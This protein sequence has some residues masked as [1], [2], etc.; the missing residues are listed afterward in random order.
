MGEKIYITG[1]MGSQRM[2]LGQEIAKEKNLLLIDLDK[3]IEKK[4]GRTIK[5]ISMMMGEHAYHDKEY[6][7]LK[8]LQEKE[9]FVLV[10][11][12]G[13]LFDNMCEDIIAQGKVV[14]ADW[15]ESLETLWRQ[16]KDDKSL[17]YA[18]LDVLRFKAREN[19]EGQKME[20][21]SAYKKFCQI[22][23]E[24]KKYFLKYTK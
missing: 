12:D 1:P 18:F 6:H 10:C 13:I 24:R 3:E 7:L 20:E 11:G 19:P 23:E 21:A 4:D 17:P 22:H 5:K 16:A 15:D 2:K 14:I 8:E 9:G